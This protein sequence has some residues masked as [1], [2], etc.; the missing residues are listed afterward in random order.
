MLKFRLLGSV[1]WAL[2]LWAVVFLSPAWVLALSV[3]IIIGI[4]LYEF[5]AMVSKKGIPVYRYFGIITGCLIPLTTYLR[6]SP[7]AEMEF[8]L[9]TTVCLC[10]FLLQLTRR[11]TEQALTGIATTILGIFYVSWM[12]SYTVKLRVMPPLNMDG[13]LVVLFLIIITKAGDVGAY[14]IGTLFGRHQLIPRISPKKTV[15]G[16][17]SALVVSFFAAVFF[18]WMLPAVSMGHIFTI[19]FL[20]SLTGQVGDLSE[21]LIK[22]DCKVKD[23]G[24]LWPGLGGMLDMIDSIIFTAPILYFYL[25]LI[26]HN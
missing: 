15:E 16:T 12:F 11:N 26:P 20:L 17:V 7:T 25:R 4:G 14:V 2:C 22:R 1:L 5:Y 19:G 10:V 9:I 6:L 24:T 8:I 23:S 18:R 3:T 21:S 13:R